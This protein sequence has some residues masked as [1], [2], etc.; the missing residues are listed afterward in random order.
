MKKTPIFTFPA[1]LL[2]VLLLFLAAQN[3]S[4][5]EKWEKHAASARASEG[6][7]AYFTG[8]DF[9]ES[10]DPAPDKMI[11]RGKTPWKTQTL[12]SGVRFVSL[13]DSWLEVPALE[14]FK[15]KDENGKSVCR[16]FSVEIRLRS[17]GQGTQLGGGGA[18]N[19]MICCQGNGYW[20]GLRVVC[21]TNSGST[22]LN[23]GKQPSCASSGPLNSYMNLSEN[24]WHH[25]C[26][27]WDGT[28]I[29]LYIDGILVS[30][31]TYEGDFVPDGSGFRL[32][33]GGAGVG[34]LNMDVCEC[35]VFSRALSPDEIFAHA[36]GIESLTDAQRTQ[37]QRLSQLASEK[38]W[39]DLPNASAELRK[40]FPAEAFGTESDASKESVFT[41]PRN[42]LKFQQIFMLQLCGR[43]SDARTQTLAV[44]KDSKIPAAER[45]QL[46]KM[47]LP[48]ETKRVFE[49]L[50]RETALEIQHMQEAG[51][52]SLTPRQEIV[53]RE[54]CV[55][56][57]LSNPSSSKSELT[58]ASKEFAA[59]GDA[60]ASV[61][62]GSALDAKR[63]EMQYREGLALFRAKNY[64]KA[65]EIFRLLAGSASEGEK[66]TG[67][68]VVDLV[69]L[70]RGAAREMYNQ[71]QFLADSPKRLF[72]SRALHHHQ[73]DEND[74]KNQN[75]K[76]KSDSGSN[77]A[78]VSDAPG[79]AEDAED[80]QNF[81]LSAE[82]T[83]G[84]ELEVSNFTELEAARDR[85]RE[86][87]QLND[88][89]LPAGGVKIVILPGI[90]QMTRTFSLGAQDAGSG[91]TPI[92][93]TVKDPKKTVF[94]GGLNL[95]QHA[96]P[97]EESAKKSKADAEILKRLTADAAKNVFI[98]HL[99]EVPEF[100]EVLKAL[101]DAKLPSL[102]RRGGGSGPDAEPWVQ[103]YAVESRNPDD[104]HAP[105]Y[106]ELLTL[107]RYPNAGFLNIN[108]VS[109]G[110]WKSEN[111][112][113]PAIFN[114]KEP[115]DATR[116]EAW[117][118]A[119]NPW[120]FGSWTALWTIQMMP[121]KDVDVSEKTIFA[122]GSNVRNDYPFFVLNVL[123][124]L[125]APGEWFL[126]RDSQTVY[127]WKDAY[128]GKN[129]EGC[130][131]TQYWISLFDQPFVTMKEAAWTSFEGFTMEFGTRSAVKIEGGDH[132]LLVDCTLRNFGTWGVVLNGQK[133]GLYACNLMNFAGGAVQMHGGKTTPDGTQPAELFAEN[134]E[135]DGFSLIDLAYTPAFHIDGAGNR[136]THCK[137]HNS[138]HHAF[139]VEGM[140][141]KIEFCEVYDVVYQGDDQ[142][143]VD[144]WANP[145]LRGTLFRGNYWHHVG[146]GCLEASYGGDAPSMSGAQRAKRARKLANRINQQLCGQ[147]GIRLDDA[148][149][150]VVI[151]GNVFQECSSKNFGCIQI[152]G[153]K[154]NLIDN[155]VFIGSVGCVSLTPWG[156]SRWFDS[157]QNKLY[158]YM[159]NVTGITDFSTSGMCPL[160]EK[161]P[162]LLT[163]KEH[164]D[165]NF[166]TRN[167][168]LNCKEFF[169]RD[170]GT[171]EIFSN[172][173]LSADPSDFCRDPDA[174]RD[175]FLRFRIPYES[176]LF[177]AAGMLPLSMDRMGLYP[178]GRYRTEK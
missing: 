92:L 33:N 3:T 159:K 50:P 80:V 144:M 125:D 9:L 91:E 140:E 148:I 63:W 108:E 71:T 126:D 59:L 99:S 41:N 149:S 55:L 101:P 72:S 133:S 27:A 70:R 52:I 1:V 87:K 171:N 40:T 152:H 29:R 7:A 160:M 35:A 145:A 43:F 102:G 81:L 155:N 6:L 169:L 164:H 122:G 141:Q 151:T 146:T 26:A 117:K 46:G 107:A 143:A 105:N 129:V 173:M 84:L 106:A 119:P 68:G 170:N 12:A 156:E 42:S 20:Q 67:P 174:E 153:G 31:G 167:L 17:R 19:G 28:N 88:G 139:R 24:V 97:L 128:D 74:W 90:Y 132:N 18:K 100:S 113:Q 76:K 13:D 135:I 62:E 175:G 116:L 83:F 36:Y 103:L 21:D 48:N 110:L 178:D 30:S 93:Y 69:A 150:S 121:L 86:Y 104:F 118:N 56:E 89:K 109:Q 45:A 58:A 138:P 4:A 85:L 163:L 114:V 123:E 78:G 127:F 120:L 131:E 82:H 65:S 37:I 66:S 111:A 16:A 165:R 57:T 8:D 96:V 39:A 166:F 54:S 158:P 142:G 64:S 154:D 10:G 2:T 61:L 23:I 161:Y 77:A 112:N 51:L 22:N 168:V 5:D 115:L 32:G 11:W 177:N 38:Q 60:Y 124:E 73:L 157:L 15:A 94:T 162:D 136:V 47:L 147:G 75:S 44:L 130:K 34:T 14:L 98:V 79:V 95:T 172:L 134:T 25:V 49:V 176:P 137:I 53:L